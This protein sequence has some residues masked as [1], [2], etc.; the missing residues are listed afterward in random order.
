MLDCTPSTGS[1]TLSMMHVWYTE[2]QLSSP[3]SLLVLVYPMIQPTLLFGLPTHVRVEQIE[4]TPSVVILSLAADTSEAACPLCQH[5]SH[6]VH[7]RYTRTLQ[8]LPCVGK[9]LRLLVV[10]RRFLCTNQGC[11]RKI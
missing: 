11:A 6:R 9:A 2:E 4:I 8:D 5:A 10:V 1:C 7:S 3:P